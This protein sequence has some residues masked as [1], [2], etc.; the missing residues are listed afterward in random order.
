MEEFDDLEIDGSM[1]LGRQKFDIFVGEG[2]RLM[3]FYLEKQP[4][5]FG[6]KPVSVYDWDCAKGAENGRPPQFLTLTYYFSAVRLTPAGN[7]N[8]T[9]TADA[10]RKLMQQTGFQSEATLE[11]AIERI[12][13]PVA[14]RIDW[15]KFQPYFN[16]KNKA[17]VVCWVVYHDFVLRS[18][19]APNHLYILSRPVN[20]SLQMI[21]TGHC[22]AELEEEPEAL[23]GNALEVPRDR[24]AKPFLLT[25]TGTVPESAVFLERLYRTRRNV[26]REKKR[27]AR[28]K[29]DERA[30]KQRNDYREELAA[31]D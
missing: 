2:T 9:L 17:T 10:G 23:E 21:I 3:D 4:A 30:K 15:S 28:A 27:A 31:E 1:R 18:Q 5:Q 11:Q 8:D 7:I 29:E 25:Q 22:E 24:R 14:F 16:A 12:V 26:R 19:A 20:Y 6:R 13:V